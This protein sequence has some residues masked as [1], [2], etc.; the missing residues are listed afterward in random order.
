MKWELLVIDDEP[1]I[2]D[3]LAELLTEDDINVTKAKN[4]KE[5][6]ALMQER[7][8]DVVISDL[9]MP[10]MDGRT[11][12]SM[13]R[14]SGIIIPHIFFSAHVR[15]EQIEALKQAGVHA[16]IGKPHFEK[17]SVEINSILTRKELVIQSSALFMGGE[18][19]EPGVVG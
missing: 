11:M 15:H 19:C 17:L 6:L 13:A 7:D 1:T 5:G 14:A 10:V 4:G 9:S 16:V 2:L 18:S 8:F 3:T 12:F